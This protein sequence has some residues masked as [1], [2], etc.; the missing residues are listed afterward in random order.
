[1]HGND[2]GTP[3]ESN[4][5]GCCRPSCCRRR[6][7]TRVSS[8][9]PILVAGDNTAQEVGQRFLHHALQDEGAHAVHLYRCVLIV[10]GMDRCRFRV[11]I[12]SENDNGRLGGCWGGGG[13]DIHSSIHPSIHTRPTMEEGTQIQAGFSKETSIN[14]SEVRRMRA[15]SCDLFE[16]CV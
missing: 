12:G 3:R 4:D 15:S 9:R 16:E 13:E 11:M 1:M 6:R 10:F 14:S 5:R 7:Q 2:V 8:G